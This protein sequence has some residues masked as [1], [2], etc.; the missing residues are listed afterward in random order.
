MNN[1]E[2]IK[3]EDGRLCL[4]LAEEE[5]KNNKYYYL[6]NTSNTNDYIIRKVQGN[7]LVGLADEVEFNEALSLLF[8][9]L[10]RGEPNV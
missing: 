5:V 10:K 8:T 7:N 3:L 9:K 1:L 6:L 2:L 4:I